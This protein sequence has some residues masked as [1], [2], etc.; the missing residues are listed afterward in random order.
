MILVKDSSIQNK[1][2]IVVI[3]TTA[4]ALLL[5][6]IAFIIN[7]ALTLQRS[8]ISEL[9]SMASI[10]G[11]N[12]TAAIVFGDPESAYE[13]LRSLNKRNNIV[14]AA[15]FT[16]DGEVFAHY[17]RPGTTVSLGLPSGERTYH[18]LLE[19]KSEIVRD[20]R[21]KNERIGSIFIRSDLAGLRS[22]LIRHIA[23]VMIVMFIALIVAIFMATKMGVMITGPIHS[24]TTTARKIGREQN[25]KLRVEKTSNDELGEFVEHFN[26]MLKEIESRDNEL[27]RHRESLEDQVEERTVALTLVNAELARARDEAEEAAKRMSYQAY[28]DTLTDLPNRAMLSEQLSYAVDVAAV[29]KQKIALIFLDLDRFKIINDSLGHGVGDELL[30]EVA[31]RLQQCVRHGDT[32]ARL[33]GDEFV[34]L[35]PYLLDAD[36]IRHIADKVLNVIKKPVHVDEHELYVST[37]MGI[38]IYPEDGNDAETLMKN[39]DASMYRAKEHGGSNYV[40]YSHGL[41]NISKEKLTLENEMHRALERDEFEVHYQPKVDL[42]N[43]QIVGAEALVRWRHPDGTLWSPD[44]FIPA[45]EDTDLILPIGNRVLEE[46]CK[47]NI[48][49]QKHGINN[50]TVAVNLSSRQVYHKQ[51]LKT[52]NRI[53]DETGMEASNLE[54]ELTESVAMQNA[55]ETISVLQVLQNMGCKISIDDFGTGYS[56]LSYL[57]SLPAHAV[58]ID[59][60]FTRGLPDSRE[61]AAIALAIINMSHSLSMNVVAE[62]VETP[63][64]LRYYREQG[65]DYVQGTLLGEPMTSEQFM[66][67]LDKQ[68]APGVVDLPVK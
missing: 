20:I 1:V 24:L 29:K 12:S 45:A 23:I 8:V 38:S 34:I 65:C 43:R 19:D 3:M 6:S 50:L 14:A 42:K 4:A 31:T 56:S 30:V 7:D 53:L 35:L 63:E 33:G 62:G 64:Q 18:S 37:S 36:D 49:W 17:L 21:L 46:A 41:D 61:D 13:T 55:K 57:K 25:Y 60:S 22:Q 39:A 26:H 11:A 5:S 44:K 9:D 32:V 2:S 27:D 47:Q 67:F 15:I 48:I 10:V 40:F 58:K 51:I 68:S 59:Q 28:H 54:F 16:N 66:Q 52:V